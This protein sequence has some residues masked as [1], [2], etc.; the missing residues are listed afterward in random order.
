MPDDHTERGDRPAARLVPED[1]RFPEPSTRR[2]RL[3]RAGLQNI[4]DYEDQRFVFEHG[5]LL[6]RG[7][8]ES[9][10]TKALELLLP[11]LLDANL[12]P[13]RLDPFRS[14]ARHMRWNLINDDNPEVNVAIGYV[15][16]E[17]GRVEA[18]TARFCTIGAG[19]R[20]K[21]Q[22]PN[23]DS[24]YFVTPSRIDLDFKLHDANRV[25][26]ERPADVPVIARLHELP[27][28]LWPASSE[29]D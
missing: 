29:P 15:W 2:W 21:R 18:G 4:W 28:L 3:L 25:P 8:N 7:Q 9:G 10:K 5:R 6:L 11:F 17:F 20:A 26:R 27:P 1:A 23:V 13:T 22:T 16:L 19:L 12:A 14:N 24:W